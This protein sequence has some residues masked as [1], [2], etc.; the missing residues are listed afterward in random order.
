MNLTILSDFLHY[1]VWDNALQKWFLSL[2][3]FAVIYFF[4]PLAQ[5]KAARIV[6]KI[7]RKTQTKVD[8]LAVDIIEKIGKVFIFFVAIALAK[9][10]LFLPP[11]VH[12]WIGFF[13]LATA[14][15]EFIKALNHIISF[16]V[17]A[18]AEHSEEG[19]GIMDFA[20][21]VI[22]MAVW[23]IAALFLLQNLGI[24]VSSLIA[25]LGIGGIAVALALQNVL[26]DMFSS[27]SIF[28]DKPFKVGDFI[29]IDNQKGTVKKIGI[30]TTRIQSLDGEEIIIPNSDLT[31]ARI[32]NYK[33][34][35]KRRAIFMIGVEY[36]TSVKKL[37]RIPQIIQ[38]IIDNIDDLA[39]ERVNFKEFGV[40]SLNFETVFWVNSN[41]YKLYA[42]KLEKIN[43]AI[44]EAFEKE[45]IA[46]AFPTQTIFVNNA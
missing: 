25:G 5:K 12:R 31:N 38:A 42:E 34:M 9:Q 13:V 2:L 3:I 28:L 17:H 32:Q 36:A 27:F 46:F 15:Y 26:G 37:K 24:N 1:Q 4:A 8:D 43:F 22:K 14:I 44:L 39:I 41:D 45:G 20:G 11:T 33:R 6:E 40:S 23:V 10:V 35:E 19:S 29:I 7:V 30:K 18:A 21:R 16:V